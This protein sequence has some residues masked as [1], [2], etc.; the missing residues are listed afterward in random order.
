MQ[1]HHRQCK[2]RTKTLIKY[3]THYRNVNIVRSKNDLKNLQK[4]IEKNKS[5]PI[6]KES[7]ILSIDKS[8]PNKESIILSIDKSIPIDKESI[9]LSID[10][11][12]PIDKESI[13]LSIDKS[14]PIDKGSIVNIVRSKNDLKNLQ[15]YIEKNKSIPIDKE[16]IVLSI[17]KVRE[18]VI[19]FEGNYRITCIANLPERSYPEYV[20]VLIQFY[21]HQDEDIHFEDGNL[22]RLPKVP[23]NWPT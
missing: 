16:S 4:Y 6:D 15:K 11:S 19:L 22:P 21:S 12:I 9:I 5:I 7:I 23:K 2:I 10:K 3:R 8:I 1:R 20:K 17:D 14:I 13:I 18:T